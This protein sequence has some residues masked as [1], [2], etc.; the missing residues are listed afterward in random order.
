ARDILDHQLV[1]IDGV[2]VIRAADLLLAQFGSRVRLVG[3]DVS[4][5]SLLRRLGPKRWRGRPTPDRVIDW[6]A[7][8]PFGDE[9]TDTPANVRLREPHA[10][11][12]RLRPG[13][14]ADLLEDLGRPGRQE[15]LATLDEATAADALEEMDPDELEALLREA[16]PAQAAGLVA[17]MEPDEAVDAL[18]DLSPVEREELLE[19]MPEQKARQLSDLLTYRE[20]RAGGFMTSTLARAQPDETV[21]EVRGR[22]AERTEHRTELDGV[23]VVDD[24]GVLLADVALFDLLVADGSLSMADL[25]PGEDEPAPVTVGTEATVEDVAAQL[26]ES[27]RSSVLVVDE[28]YRPVGRILADDVLYALLPE[29]GRMHFP[30]LLQ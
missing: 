1:D 26:I 15:L 4:M 8:E 28:D 5:Q 9:L 18:R 16:D 23:V 21:A 29:Q 24:Q 6:S 7:V 30:R 12:R 3:V 2:Q 13:E 11:L 17:A 25:L 14:L 19:Q 22:L 10:A 27:R 20:D